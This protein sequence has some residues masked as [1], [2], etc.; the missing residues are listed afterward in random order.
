MTWDHP[1]YDSLLHNKLV[2]HYGKIN[3]DVTINDIVSSV[4]TGDLQTVVYDLTDMKMWVANA[5]ADHEKGPL[6]A[7]D[8][9]FI[10]FDMNAIFSK[11][12]NFSK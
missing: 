3:A 9:Q 7:Y 1:K 4:K 10:E 11:A 2:E 12:K 8:R 5:S 6:P